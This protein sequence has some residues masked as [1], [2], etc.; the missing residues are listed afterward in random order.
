MD[1]NFNPIGYVHHTHQQV[2]RH[3]SVSD[4]EGELI[5]NPEFKDG[6]QGLNPGDLIF[7]IFNFHLSPP[8]KS[9]NL[10]QVPPHLLEIKGVFSICSPIRP[11][12]IGL[13]VVRILDIKE[14]IVRVK[15]V[16]MHN[17]TPILDIKPYNP[18]GSVGKNFDCCKHENSKKE[19]IKRQKKGN[20]RASTLMKH[21]LNHHKK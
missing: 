1:L 6:L 7:V 17:G 12:P 11:N 20:K 8:F 4:L 2:P 9:E 19:I 14:N 16:D 3:C 21:C 18:Y 15:G 10:R 5:I 13:S